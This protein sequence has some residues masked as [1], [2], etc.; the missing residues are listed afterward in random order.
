V[1]AKQSIMEAMTAEGAAP[2]FEKSDAETIF[3]DTVTLYVALEKTNKY[4]VGP[5]PGSAAPIYVPVVIEGVEYATTYQ[6]GNIN[7]KLVGGRKGDTYQFIK[8]EFIDENGVSEEDQSFG[9]DIIIERGGR[10]Q[11]A[12]D[13]MLDADRDAF[14]L[15]G[16]NTG[17]SIED[18]ILGD[19]DLTRVQ[20][21]REG[22]GMSLEVSYSGD[23]LNTLDA[24][25]YKQYT[26]GD[27]TY[28]V[29]DLVLLYG[30]VDPETGH[31]T[32]ARFDLGES[33]R[34]ATTFETELKTFDGRD[35]IL[36]SRAARKDTF[37]LENTS[38]ADKS[39][40]F[41]VY[42]KDFDYELDSIE[43]R[44]YGLF[45][46]FEFE[47]V[48]RTVDAVDQDF[49]DKVT[50]KTDTGF[51]ISLIFIGSDHSLDEWRMVIS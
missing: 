5:T 35:A 49:G 20:T 50:V 23:K 33:Q 17:L 1:L 39:S 12:A 19:L 30:V 9:S 26:P 18:F 31:E 27:S 2:D 10:Q 37:V 8:S 32:G 21:G 11:S 15:V 36:L 47:D 13:G 7:E 40:N 34:N 6:P 51:D 14:S 38:A 48:V 43:F 42:F 41:E 25:I 3:T 16:G 28:R 44:G 4:T 29:E 24:T 45:T 22:A 46:S